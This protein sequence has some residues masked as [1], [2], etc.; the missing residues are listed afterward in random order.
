MA[1]IGQS[2][3]VGTSATL[4][5]QVVDATT[6]AANGYTTSANPNIFK[7]ADVNAPIPLW[8][9]IPSTATVAFGGSTVTT[10]TGAVVAGSQI[11]SFAYNVVGNDSLYACVA[12]GTATLQLLAL[13]Q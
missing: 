3:T 5:F 7:T 12:S 10:T 9:I 4:V 1:A 8:V 2:I 11:S 6:Y 13:R